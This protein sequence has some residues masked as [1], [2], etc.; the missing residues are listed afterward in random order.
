MDHIYA[1][2]PVRL[3]PA[4]SRSWVKHSTTEPLLSHSL[5]WDFSLHMK[6]VRHLSYPLSREHTAKTDQTAP[7]AKKTFSML[8]SAE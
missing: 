7:E 3:E 1:V 6:T 8:N 5:T 4:A 2:T